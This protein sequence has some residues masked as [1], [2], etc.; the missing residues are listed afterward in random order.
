MNQFWDSLNLSEDFPRSSNFWSSIQLDPSLPLAL[1]M[2]TVTDGAHYRESPGSLALPVPNLGLS[3]SVHQQIALRLCLSSNPVTVVAGVPGSGKSR[4]AHHVAEV[5]ISHERR[6]LILSR[7]SSLGSDFD[8]LPG[9]VYRNFEL[10]PPED[11]QLEGKAT[12]SLQKWMHQLRQNYLGQTAM[13]F[14]PLPLLPDFLVNQLRTPRKL[15]RFL[16]IITEKL[17]DKLCNLLHLE[18]PEQST[19]RLALLARKLQQIAP[20]LQQQLWL[21]QQAQCLSD[22]DVLTLTHQ[23]L[24]LGQFTVVD[25]ISSNLN[26]QHHQLWSGN[27]S[28][29]CTIV[30]EAETLSWSDLVSI[31]A[32]TQKL[33]LLGTPAATQPQRQSFH[34][35]QPFNWLSTHLFPCYHHRLR[36]QFRLHSTLAQTVYPA[37][38][39]TWIQNQPR[40]RLNLP[41]NSRIMWLDVP[42]TSASLAFNPWEIKQILSQCRQWGSRLAP[43]VGILTFTTALKN[44]I[45]QQLTPN[46]QSIKV[47]TVAEWAG[48]ERPVMYVILGS[49]YSLPQGI[50]ATDLEIALTRAR[51]YLV[52]SGNAAEWQEYSPSI[53]AL[54][55]NADLLREREVVL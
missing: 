11:D 31:A 34:T 18:F 24:H 4:I 15:E 47:G 17:T 9:L 52:I 12:Q 2:D 20:L 32:R 5:A 28:F 14:L 55:A 25:R 6:V 21:S 26:L 13:Q 54:L 29:D 49:P 51:D 39:N 36:E 27:W 10:D 35:Q 16:P 45:L 23:I 38:Y 8:Q 44:A 3:L 43:Q 53:R 37:L 41:L 40:P 30:L 19:T 42:P 50:P 33:I 22:A 48:Q 7:H 1:I 46:L